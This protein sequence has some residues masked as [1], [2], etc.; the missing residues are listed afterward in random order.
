[1]SAR[2]ETQ[3]PPGKPNY[4][5]VAKRTLREFKDDEVTE[6]AA[7]VAYHAIFAIPPLIISVIAISALV[8][9][10]T[11]IDVSGR[12]IELINQYAP[13]DMRELLTGLVEGAV[14]QAGPGAALFGVITSLAVALWSGSN[15]VS[16]IMRA[17]N[18]AYDIEEDRSFVTKKLISIGLT[19]LLGVLVILAFG[20]VVFGQAIGNWIADWL[21]LGSVFDIVWSILRYVLPLIFIMFVLA[22]LYYFAP[23]VKQSFRWIS[24]GSI[25]ATLAWIVV[26]FG[27]R[28]YLTF[29]NP[30][31]A[32][33]TLGSVV[34]L[35]FFLYVSAIVFIVGAEI[36]ALI[37]RQYDPATVRD[38][39]HHPNKLED[40]LDLAEVG[41]TA[42]MMD[43]REGTNITADMPTPIV[44]TPA[45]PLTQPDPPRGVA[46]RAASGVWS[47]VLASVIARFMRGKGDKERG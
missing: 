7:G 40:E 8:N 37:G 16:T 20:L 24:P 6:L 23:N 33:G 46:S 47:L 44:P 45:E 39:A 30:G 36:N 28:I 9:Q 26:V 29:S 25:F 42:R 31:S 17:F 41:Y 14:E 2:A 18:R 34:V 11:S 22:V 10:I 27:F 32:Y 38:L 4:V 43:Q 5:D 15:G 21:G 3:Q 1:M 19:V 13:G 12:M 35:L